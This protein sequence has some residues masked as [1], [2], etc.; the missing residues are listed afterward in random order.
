M[1][2]EACSSY[3]YSRV[4]S[5]I[6]PYMNMCFQPASTTPVSQNM[7]NCISNY[8]HSG[9]C[10]YDQECPSNYCENGK[11]AKYTPGKPMLTWPLT[12]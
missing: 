2:D 9:G 11:C 4:P 7:L 5:V 10:L 6:T 1:N 3:Q 8:S 12:C